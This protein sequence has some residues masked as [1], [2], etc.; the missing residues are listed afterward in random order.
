MSGPKQTVFPMS[1]KI[2]AAV[3]AG[4]LT[5]TFPAAWAGEISDPEK[6]EATEAPEPGVLRGRV[7]DAKT[8]ELIIGATVRVKDNTEIYTTTGLDGSFAL[9]LSGQEP[10]ATLVYS[11]LG[12]KSAEF[13]LSEVSAEEE[14]SLPIE[15]VSVGL[16]EA[17]VMAHNPGRTESGARSMERKAMNVINVM[18]AKAIELSPDVT[19]ANALGRISGITLERSASGEGQYA[20]LRGMD[21]RYNYTLVNG[22]KIP[23]P[24]N[25][26]RYVPLD[27]FPADMLDRLEV[28]KSLTA[29]MEGDGIGG[30]VNMVMKDAPDRR[31]L[32][33]YA[34]V[35]Y[36]A[37][38]F[39]RSFATFPTSGIQSSSP[40]ERNGSSYSPTMDDFTLSNLAQKN[41]KFVPD[42]SA[43]FTYGDRFLDKKL[44]LILALTAQNTHRGKNSDIYAESGVPGDSITHREYSEQQTRIG[45]HLKADYLLSERHKLALYASY[46][47]LRSQQVRLSEEDQATSVRMKLNKQGIFNATL[48][49]EHFFADDDALSL[50]WRGS[51]A[52]A[53]NKTPDN[54]EV[55]LTTT[56]TATYTLQTVN[57]QTAATRKW[58]HNSDEDFSGYADLAYNFNFSASTLVVKAGGMYR[59]KNR[60]SYY[61]EYTFQPASG[62]EEQVRYG[63][64][65][66]NGWETFDE[67]LYSVK[68]GINVDDPLNYDA[69]EDIGAAYLMGVLT[70]G[71]W[72]LNAGLR[73]EHTKQTYELKY[74]KDGVENTGN[75]KYWD[76]LPSFHAKFH[77]HKDA[78]LRFSYVHAINR[79]SFFEIVPYSIL[80]DD[81]DER[82]NPD[83]KHT[84]A[85]NVDIRYEWFP[86]PSEQ[87]MAGIFYKRIKNPI[88]YGF[89]V[90][91][92]DTYYTPQNF[93]TAHNAGLEIDLTKY[94]RRFG[95]KAN[96]TYTL[97]RIKTD[98][99]ITTENPDETADNT[100]ITQTVSQTRPLN[101]QAA[102]V[103]NLSLLYKDTKHGWDAQLAFNYTGKRLVIVS[104]YLDNDSWVDGYAQLDAS[105]EK[106]FGQSGWCLFAKVNNILNLPI[107]QY[108]KQNS[109]VASYLEAS[110]G[111]S[112]VVEHAGGLLER[113]E[114]HGQSFLIG[115]RFKLN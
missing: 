56:R 33:V 80:G 22:V 75:Q 23:S 47:F 16:G 95:I 41:T 8:G 114:W 36:D 57:T 86:T 43:G 12:Y 25:K 67:I 48:S 89:E 102:H 77:V 53:T 107:V 85:I 37:L 76:F 27:I 100:T 106:R 39:E 72:E 112:A 31:M 49:G 82:G 94:F 35:G 52:K 92:Q 93:G 20:I 2:I 24:D 66:Q 21:K 18:S 71:R 97:S 44:G 6:P 55:F 46:M 96:Y 29:D 7:V 28:T 42:F 70:F 58:E 61:N 3:L 69:G 91:G 115:V 10:P 30:A 98:K 40:N 26:N 13:Q 17:L 19:V 62:Y 84:E 11:C 111:S 103:A 87:F 54:A 45:S 15:E 81:Y 51:Y 14:L 64:E 79:P 9:N 4:F 104:R 74:P 65:A 1:L 83:L 34:T 68:R 5:F 63:T 32:N 99:T 110:S 60:T 101:G 108:V 78:N 105:F 38:Y 73:A 59:H 90:S 113:K 88:E 109:R 50:N